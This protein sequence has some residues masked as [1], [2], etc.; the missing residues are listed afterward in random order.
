MSIDDVINDLQ[1]IRKRYGNLD[2]VGSDE[3]DIGFVEVKKFIKTCSDYNDII[4]RHTEDL[5]ENYLEKTYIEDKDYNQYFIS[6]GLCVK[7]F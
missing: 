5:D 6:K 7:V 2:V 3:Y 4:S 1:E